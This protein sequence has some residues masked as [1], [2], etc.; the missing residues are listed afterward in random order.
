V[1]Q[2]GTQLT[3]FFR[4]HDFELLSWPEQGEYGPE[5]PGRIEAICSN[6]NGLADI[7]CVVSEHLSSAPV[8]CQLR[9]LGYSGPVAMIPHVNPYPTRN[10]LHALLW[11]KIWGPRD[12]VVVGSTVTA[13]KY[14]SLFGMRSESI[15]TYGVDETTFFPRE[16]AASRRQFEL[17][18]GP[19]LLYTGR[20]ARDKNIGALLVVYR[21]IH[22]V[23]PDAQLVMAVTFRDHA[24]W[25]GLKGHMEGVRVLEWLAADKLAKLYSAADL[26]V[27]CATSYFETFPRSPVEARACGTR[28]VVPDWDGFRACVGDNDKLVPVDFLVAPLYDQWSYA[29]VSLPEM[30]RAC[31]HALSSTPATTAPVPER[32]TVSATALRLNKLLQEL[33][34]GATLDAWNGKN[35]VQPKRTIL[36]AVVDAL[37]ASDLKELRTLTTCSE[38][39]L[40]TIRPA[41]LRELYVALFG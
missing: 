6:L 19:V 18:S 30:V 26:F 40:P 5:V 2:E 21:S 38:G 25:H 17:S 15:P 34:A 8:V 41:L 31:G 36:Q 20:F 16:K 32:F 10:L 4:D 12:V 35:D 22:E 7:D 24:Y 14:E 23:V 29:M 13:Q 9:K 11:S 39:E 33:T 28:S 3:Q 27:S 37:G 1:S